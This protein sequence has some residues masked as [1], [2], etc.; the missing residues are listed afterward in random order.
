MS[1]S[2]DLRW[3][4]FGLLSVL[5]ATA[6][7]AVVFD[8]RL[9]AARRAGLPTRAALD[10]APFGW[11]VLTK[12]DRYRYANPYARRLLGLPAERGR[13][14]VADWSAQM[15][16]DV[17]T[18]RDDPASGGRYRVMRV[19]ED[20]FASWWA[21]PQANEDVVYLLDVTA[22]QHSEEASRT[23][24]SGLAHELR[25][26]IG[27][28]QAHIEAQHIP[29]LP[30]ETR[31]QSLEYLRAEVQR[32][33]RMVQLML[34]LG[35]LDITAEIERRPVELLAVAQ[36]ALAQAKAAADERGIS[37][38]LQADA[39]LPL[40]FGDRDR[41]KQVFLNLLDNAVKYCR[42]ADRVTVTLRREADG[43]RCAVCD[44]GPGIP[45]QHVP[46]LTRRFYRAAPQAV[47]GSGLGLALVQEVLVR[48]RSRLEIE[49]RAEGD[50]TG[51]CMSFL[52]PAD[53]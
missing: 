14:P 9:S 6:A 18:A 29:D 32:M 49:S 16:D 12:T 53:A 48:H 7:L 3:V 26:P 4:L 30:A 13:I 17:D 43:I 20:R 28:L 40:V 51:T 42:P 35:R 19:G 10:R 11:L 5:L 38:G 45:A 34:E 39:S 25:T 36:E 52:L 15:F 33:A 24:L 23:L 31:A 8:R 37:L 47:E 44:T 22:Q 46:H 1:G 21:F 27:T 50:D 41:L 2:F